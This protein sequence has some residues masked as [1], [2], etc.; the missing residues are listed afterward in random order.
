[1]A[2]HNVEGVPPDGTVEQVSPGIITVLIAI[3]HVPLRLILS[4]PVNAISSATV[5]H[6]YGQKRA[7]KQTRS[8]PQTNTEVDCGRLVSG[9]RSAPGDNNGSTCLIMSETQTGDQTSRVALLPR[10]IARQQGTRAP[11]P[12]G[13]MISRIPPGYPAAKHKAYR[14]S[15][16]LSCTHG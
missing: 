14:R 7:Q 9:W 3:L 15:K 5:F 16:D 8:A 12:T 11:G 2:V 6:G 4:E 10:T 1:M 13:G